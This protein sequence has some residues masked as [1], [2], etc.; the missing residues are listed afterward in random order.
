MIMVCSRM[1]KIDLNELGRY[2]ST[3]FDQLPFLSGS[4][5]TF[6]VPAVQLALGGSRIYDTISNGGSE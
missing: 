5:S 4:N 2:Y 6:A 1:S 3:V